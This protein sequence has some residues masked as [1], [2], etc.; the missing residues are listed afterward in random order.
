MIT[1]AIS[2]FPTKKKDATIASVTSKYVMPVYAAAFGG[3]SSDTSPM[4]TDKK[5]EAAMAIDADTPTTSPANP[6]SFG[7]AIELTRPVRNM[8]RPRA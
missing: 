2:R 1:S 5:L 8:S 3:W 7:F 6:I 4:S